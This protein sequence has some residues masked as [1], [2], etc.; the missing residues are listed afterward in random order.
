MASLVRT[1]VVIALIGII[2]YFN[3]NVINNKLEDWFATAPDKHLNIAKK[4]ANNHAINECLKEIDIAIMEMEDI[5]VFSDNVSR[6]LIEKSI[7]DL[8]LLENH[9]QNH[10]LNVDELNLVFAK[11]I[12]SLAYTYLKI[13][14]DELRHDHEIKAVHS[15]KIVIDHLY[16]S[17][18]FMKKKNID[19]EKVLIKHI[20]SV[21]D[22]I[23]QTDNFDFSSLDR[24]F[25][26]I[27]EIIAEEEL[28][29]KEQRAG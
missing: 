1:V 3:Q 5:E 2:Y 19:D 10:E 17:M 8:Q 26:E 9:I 15:L 25:S 18:S 14:E 6:D 29:L 13:S 11:G 12:N 16:N 20:Y 22:S 4:A 27:Q 21:I 23:Q 24:L 7:E 28:K